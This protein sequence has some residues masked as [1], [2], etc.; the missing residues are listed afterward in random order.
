[1]IFNVLLNKFIKN[2][3]VLNTFLL[4]FL[5]KLL[6]K[7][8]KNL[9][10]NISG[11]IQKKI[12][13][14]YNSIEFDRI[15]AYYRFK[16]YKIVFTNGCFDIIHYGHISYLLKASEFGDILIVGLNSDDSIRRIKGEKRPIFNQESRSMV[17]ASLLFVSNVV[18]F[19]EDTPLKLIEKIRPNI[20]VKGGDY[21]ED[22][23]IGANF[24]KS[25]GGEVKII[26][27]INGYSTSKIIE[28]IKSF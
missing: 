23:I 21:T 8:V 27:Y 17:L 28:K 15:L 2:F 25:Y 12:F 3:Q 7:L 22:S 4:F 11:Y 13:F 10:M 20:L 26:N 14:D 16:D 5:I 19:N 18:V 1:M 6:N 9:L 24:V